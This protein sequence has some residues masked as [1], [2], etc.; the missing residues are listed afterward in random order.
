VLESS[1]ANNIQKH[2]AEWGGETISVKFVVTR[3]LDE[4]SEEESLSCSLSDESI[5]L[6]GDE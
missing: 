2:N 1:I 3:S 5:R 4:L 6:A